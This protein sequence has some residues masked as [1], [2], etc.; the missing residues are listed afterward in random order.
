MWF[1]ELG[2]TIIYGAFNLRIYKCI[3]KILLIIRYFKIS[4]KYR[5]LTEFQSRKARCIQLKDKDMLKILCF[6]ISCTI[7]CLLSWTILDVDYYNQGYSFIT[8][9]VVIG[10]KIFSIC[11][12]KWWNY[13]I[14]LGN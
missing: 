4:F 13:F 12:I 9:T 3:N 7:G 1:R 10:V 8:K 14:S 5:V 11:I 2:F 6:I